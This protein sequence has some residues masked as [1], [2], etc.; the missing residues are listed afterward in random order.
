MTFEN[1]R[2]EQVSYNSEL[3]LIRSKEDDMFQVQSIMMCLGYDEK[4]WGL[5]NE[6]LEK[7]GTKELIAQ[8]MKNTNLTEDRIHEARNNIEVV[9]DGTYIH[10]LLVNH[11]ACWYSPRYCHKIQ[12]ML[13]DLM[14]KEMLELEQKREADEREKEVVL[15]ELRSH[16]GKK[17]K[18]PKKWIIYCSVISLLSF[19]FLFVAFRK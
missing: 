12:V 10:R 7:D 15:K 9:I 4:K 13:D 17:D 14:K 16:F 3:K 8:I 5:V 2:Y 1:D 19:A 11:F 18:K 6:Y